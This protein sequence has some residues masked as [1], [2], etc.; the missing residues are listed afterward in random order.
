VLDRL[1]LAR[2]RAAIGLD[3]C[4]YASSAAAPLPVDVAEFFAAL[5]LPLVEVWG[6]TETSGVATGNPPGRLKIGTVGPPI[7][8]IEVR[9]T[10]DGEVLVRG[11]INTPGYHRRPEATAE[12]FDQDGWLRTGDVGELD[13]DG[14]L[15]I[16]DRKKELIITSSGK[17]LSP[18]N[19]ENLLKE[20]PLVGQALAFGDG[21]PYV[22][23]LVVLDHEVAPGWARQHQVP[24]ETLAGFARD[25]LVL[26]E[27]QRAVDGVNQRLSRIEQV[28]R[29]M[30]LPAEWTAE[31]E[32]LT[33]T[34][35]LKRRVIHAK[36]AGEL[37]A[38][39]G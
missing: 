8:G 17:N 10:G 26:A 31:S 37:E 25:Q 30:V 12:L 14:Y 23:A 36:Y 34:L 13:A 33:P 29:F 24:F 2:V 27:L 19:I 21:R 35:K 20:H 22:V 1:V 38:L 7:A 3:R 11:P 5:G 9:L 28:K 18:A 15:R 6:M 16:V 39:Y 32:E 4:E